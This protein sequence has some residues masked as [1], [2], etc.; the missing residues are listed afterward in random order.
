[1]IWTA[2]ACINQFVNAI[3]WRDNAIN[4]APVWCDISSRIIIATSV[5]IPAS[6]LTITRRL[7]KISR[8]Q[9][10]MASPKEKRI[11]M[12][13][14]LSLVVGLPVF[15]MILYYFV[16]GHRFDIFEQLGCFPVTINTPPSYVL[17]W[18]WPLFLGTISMV[19]CVLTVSSFLKRRREM[20]QFLNSN[21]QLT[22][23]RYFR[24][25]AL[26]MMDTALTVPLAI[27]A[28]WLNAVESVVSP[29]RGLADAH[30]DFSRVEQI[31]AVEWQ[32]S[33]FTVLSFYLDRWFIIFCALVFFAFFGFAEES[34]KNYTKAYW[35]IARRFGYTPKPN[36]MSLSGSYSVRSPHLPTM[37]SA[38]GALKM[39]TLKVT[40][41]ADEKR[42][43]FI[44]SVGDLSSSFSVNSNFGDRKRGKSRSS[45]ISTES[46]PPSPDELEPSAL[47]G[48]PRLLSNL[49]VPL[50]NSATVTVPS[51]PPRPATVDLDITK[52]AM[53]RVVFSYVSFFSSALALF[54]VPWF[55]QTKNIPG[56]FA[57]AWLVV[58]NL[59]YGLNAGVFKDEMFLRVPIYCDIATKLMVGLHV[60]VLTSMFCYIL[61]IIEGPSRTRDKKN[62]KDFVER[63][64]L[65]HTWLCILFPL[66][67]MALSIAVQD[68]RFDIV[69]EVGCLP[70]ISGTGWFLILVNFALLICG[71]C[72]VLGLFPEVPI[73]D[74]RL[75]RLRI[76]LWTVTL[77]IATLSLYI[78]LNIAPDFSDVSAFPRRDLTRIEIFKSLY[79]AST[80]VSE[81]RALLWTGPIFS[82]LFFVIN[83]GKD[84]LLSYQYA[85]NKLVRRRPVALAGPEAGPDFSMALVPARR[86]IKRQS[87]YDPRQRDRSLPPSN[88]ATAPPSYSV[89]SPARVFPVPELSTPD[90]AYMSHM[91]ARSESGVGQQKSRNGRREIRKAMREH[92]RTRDQRPLYVIPEAA[93][94]STKGYPSSTSAGGSLARSQNET[95]NI[96]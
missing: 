73:D 45:T 53:F 11:E 51:R 39:M 56:L 28:I 16:Q 3:V 1:M 36:A 48:I 68:R 75:C 26:S 7:F 10:I 63:R 54:P 38:S 92:A 5:A 23:S 33:H 22:I 74:F 52:F 49:P 69:E 40:T 57:L 55:I 86:R 61:L 27:F 84:A 19:Y 15:V 13:I 89:V 9:S 77:W 96:L 76:M 44:S 72:L 17:V 6:S 82:L 90:V 50:E 65:I 43:S 85:F 18:G 87:V 94:V 64:R 66:A 31:P 88:L 81:I 70:S 71:V 35:K 2:I 37:S 12:A 24:L 30:F 93:Y 46:L 4:W 83:M 32:L 78:M 80:S 25:M 20:N 91:Y 62:R 59:I 79:H 95:Y 29:W 47:H 21:T 67:Y 42:N 34:R 58:V 60:A 41:E 8:V 14:D